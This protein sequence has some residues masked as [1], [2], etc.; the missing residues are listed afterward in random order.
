[1]TFVTLGRYIF[2]G[3][4]VSVGN[5]DGVLSSSDEIYYVGPDKQM[6]TDGRFFPNEVRAKNPNARRGKAIA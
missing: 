1:M 2:L 4:M 6:R 5:Y 3:K